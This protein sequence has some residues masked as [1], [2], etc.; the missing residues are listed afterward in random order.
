MS[1]ESEFNEVQMWR[2]NGRV[3]SYTP[4]K[5]KREIHYHSKKKK[6]DKKKKLTV[7]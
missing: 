1:V 7:G 3:I 4:K 6:T 2:E 5:I